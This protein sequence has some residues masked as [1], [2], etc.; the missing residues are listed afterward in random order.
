MNNHLWIRYSMEESTLNDV[1][2]IDSQPALREWGPAGREVSD[3][4][5]LLTRSSI[6]EI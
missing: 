2:Q 4:P 1:V 6:L 3:L 5:G